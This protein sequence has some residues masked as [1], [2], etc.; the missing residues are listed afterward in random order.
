MVKQAGAQRGAQQ[1]AQQGAKR[2]RTGSRRHCLRE[3]LRCIKA[4][5]ESRLRWER[6]FLMSVK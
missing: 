4:V 3:G 2:D 1:G 5:M 6:C